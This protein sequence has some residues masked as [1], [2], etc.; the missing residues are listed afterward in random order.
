MPSEDAYFDSKRASEA[1]KKSKRGVSLKRALKEM[2]QKQAK[3][4]GKITEENFVKA[5]ALAGMKGNAGMAK[6]L[7]EYI[8]GK[9]AENINAEVNV[10]EDINIKIV[11]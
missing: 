10:K 6:L 8:D 3:E 2:F 5:C 4:G 7:F 1:G 9:V 11:D